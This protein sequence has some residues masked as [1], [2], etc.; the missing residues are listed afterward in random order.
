MNVAMFYLEVG[1][2]HDAVKY[3]L[4]AR[5]QSTMPSHFAEICLAQLHIALELQDFKQVLNHVNRAE[6][7]VE[8][9]TVEMFTSRVNVFKAIGVLSENRYKDVAQCLLTINGEGSFVQSLLQG[10]GSILSIADIGIITVLTAMSSFSVSEFKATVSNKKSFKSILLVNFKANDLATS[11]SNKEFSSLFRLLETCTDDFLYDPYI[12]MH[13]S[14]LISQ[15]KE[16]AVLEYLVPYKSVSLQRMSS[17]FGVDVENIISSL[18]GKGALAARIDGIN[19]TLLKRKESHKLSSINKI[20][21]VGNSHGRDVRRGIL[22]LSLLEHNFSVSSKEKH[23]FAVFRTAASLDA[24]NE[25][26]EEG[27]DFDDEF[28]DEV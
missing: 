13:T 11:F 25:D 6:S 22:G 10:A 19:G 3:L 1:K 7:I 14:N 26:A 21:D 2:L 24:E 4:K 27:R 18:I 12:S 23:G 9:E 8:M 15:I 20:L 17:A 28:A 16:R 5:E